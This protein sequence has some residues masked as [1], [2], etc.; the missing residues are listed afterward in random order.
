MQERKE[1]FEETVE[2]EI[3]EFELEGDSD[4]E[5]A[6]D[7]IEVAPE[8]TS[9]TD[10]GVECDDDLIYINDEDDDAQNSNAPKFEALV[11]ET[12]KFDFDDDTCSLSEKK[13]SFWQI[14]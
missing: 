14:V 13:R 7:I 3:N 12:C 11:S 5:D 8:S 4:N 9:S 10:D 1:E 6:D 2:E